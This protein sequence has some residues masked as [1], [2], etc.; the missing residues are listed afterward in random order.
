MAAL[1]FA[2]FCPR[3]NGNGWFF[4]RS[5]MKIDC[6]QQWRVK[7]ILENPE[8]HPKKLI[9]YLVELER[10][11]VLRTPPWTQTRTV[12]NWTHSKKHSLKSVR[13]WEIRR[14]LSSIWT[15][16]DHKFLFF[17]LG[18]KLVRPGYIILYYPFTPSHSPCPCTF[19]LLITAPRNVKNLNALEACKNTST[20]S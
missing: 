3:R 1:L 7:D 17:R 20:S 14:I 13:N 11:Y 8:F 18:N 6:L 16:P 15:T 9:V 12:P 19:G 5:T 10:P 2:I 4:K